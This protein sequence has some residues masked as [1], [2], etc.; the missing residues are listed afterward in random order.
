[1]TEGYISI[2]NHGA[3]PSNSPDKNDLAFKNA[4]L[5]M[6]SGSTLIIPPGDFKITNIVFNPP[7]D[8]KLLCMG[9]LVSSASGV[10]LTIGSS[11]LIRNRYTIQGLRL[12]S[13]TRDWSTGRI[14]VKILNTYS[15]EF[16]IRNIWGFE[17]N[18][19]LIG[20]NKKGCVYNKLYLGDMGAS[21][22]SLFLSA[23][24]GGWCNENNFFCGRYYLTSDIV[25]IADATHLIISHYETN[26][27]NNNHFYSP[28]FESASI[29]SKAAKIEGH[30]NTIYSPRLEAGNGLAPWIG[31]IEI[32]ANSQ[33][34]SIFPGYGVDYNAISDNGNYS[35]LY[36]NDHISFETSSS[37]VPVLKVRNKYSSSSKIHSVEDVMGI[38]RFFVKG[39]G[40]IFSNQ[41]GYFTRGIRWGTIDGTNAD[42]GIYNGTGSPEGVIVARAGSIYLNNSG[43]AGTTMYV[44]E[45]GTGNTGWIPK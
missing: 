12:K 19:E 22:N 7:D 9:R 28:S 15:S 21:K 17:R 23:D 1:M 16:H 45:S 25:E 35:K 8:C 40:E 10:A 34:T 43:G 30:F 13:S 20:T 44:K 24:N 26:P 36:L 39:S 3:L 32:T 18:L 33:C 6:V 38:E 42:R 29:L 4:I 31:A 2:L 27:L 37:S 5:E 14:G 11:T 41:F